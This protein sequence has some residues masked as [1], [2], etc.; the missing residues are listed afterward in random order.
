[1]PAWPAV[2]QPPSAS[3]TST[4][5][6]AFATP[7][8]PAPT[9]SDGFPSVTAVSMGRSARQILA[10]RRATEREWR[11]YWELK[12]A[13]NDA[14]VAARTGRFPSR[15]TRDS[16]ITA[17]VRWRQR[18]CRCANC[19]ERV[20]TWDPWA[21]QVMRC[22]KC[23]GRGI[24]S[25]AAAVLYVTAHAELQAIKV[26]IAAAGSRRLATH[27]ANGWA[28]VQTWDGLTGAQA[29]SIE[30]RILTW[31]RHDLDLEAPLAAGDMPQ[32]GHTETVGL[33]DERLVACV[34]QV[35]AHVAQLRSPAACLAS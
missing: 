3:P 34:E 10:R 30:A 4:A 7:L 15:L 8:V 14:A 33:S 16:S 9:L 35:C 1:M 12:S 22:R 17:W 20:S 29:R 13:Q 19:G 26:G 27:A 32:T 6:T 28:V 11:H 24:P 5:R 25:N 21:G 18:R 23:S 31:W 2:L